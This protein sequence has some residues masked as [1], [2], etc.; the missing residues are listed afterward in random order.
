MVTVLRQIC[1]RSEIKYTS[2]IIYANSSYTILY[3]FEIVVEP[4]SDVTSHQFCD[5]V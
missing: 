5:D 4:T 2:K 1:N 3:Y